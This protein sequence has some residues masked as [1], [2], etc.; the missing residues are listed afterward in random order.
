MI[1]GTGLDIVEIK[2]I[3]RIHEDYREAFAARILCESELNEYRNEKFQVRFLA[4]R[5][6]AKEAVAKA[7][8]TGFSNGVNPKMICVTHDDL[9]RPAITLYE[10]ARSR[11]E[12]LG[13]NVT[14]ISISDEKAYA[15]AFAVL[16]NQA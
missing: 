15:A 4:K 9:G 16:E 1:A 13:A 2:R 14:W 5:F 12:R 8:G 6:A 3:K 11:A 7:L 10:E